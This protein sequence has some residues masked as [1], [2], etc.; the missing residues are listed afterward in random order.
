MDLMKRGLGVFLAG[1]VPD[2][3]LLAVRA[4]LRPM[5]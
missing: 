5:M 2:R 3:P 4:S 1:A